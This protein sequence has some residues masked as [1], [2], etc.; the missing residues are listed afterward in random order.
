MIHRILCRIFGHKAP[1]S[2]PD[3]IPLRD[4]NT[5]WWLPLWCPRC[6]DRVVQ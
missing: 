3:K 6:G 5:R 4:P 1:T 2:L